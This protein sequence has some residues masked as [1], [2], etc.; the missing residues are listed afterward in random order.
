[1]PVLY[2]A[3]LHFSLETRVEGQVI[4]PPGMT[5]GNEVW[6]VTDFRSYAS[7]IVEDLVGE[8]TPKMHDIQ[9][10]VD[11]VHRAQADIAAREERIRLLQDQIQA[12]KDEIALSIKQARDAAQQIW[13]GPGA[14]L[15]DEY[16]SKLAALQKAIADRAKSLNLKYAPDDSYRSPEVWANAYRLALYDVPANVDSA[17]EHTWLE[18]QIKQWRDFTKKLD[19]E[20]KALREQAAQIQL[21]PTAK[22][23]D[24]NG[25][26]EDLQHRIDSTL[27]EEEPIKAELQQANADLTQVQ[28][29]EGGLD[30]K[31]YKQL[32][33]LPEGSGSI[34]KRLPLASNGRFS[35]RHIEKDYAFSE[36]EKF[37]HHYYLF[38]RAVRPDGRQYW[39]LLWVQ[40]EM[41][42]VETLE[43]I[44]DDFIS[45]KAILRPDLSPDEQEK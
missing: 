1:M 33:A 4:P 19:D 37:R 25:K 9:D 26:I 27:A 22:V 35:W 34:I 18:D 7:G 36:D 6:I 43:I 5:L 41:N 2:W 15:E 42:K 38:A 31:Y 40:V 13:D 10:G 45:T 29:S 12:A 21:A 8:R 39:A 32:Y 17:K 30:D 23:T 28:T 24:I 3:T 11:H 44:P 16:N 20:Q 14:A